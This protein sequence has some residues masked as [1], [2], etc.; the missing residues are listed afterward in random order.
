M[1]Y[2]SLQ[3]LG[4]ALLLLITMVVQSQ[5][6]ASEKDL[7]KHALHELLQTM[8]GEALEYIITPEAMLKKQLANDFSRD[9]ITFYLLDTA[10]VYAVSEN[11]KRYTYTYDEEGKQVIEMLKRFVNEQW[12]NV[13][14]EN[15]NYNDFDL[16][17]EVTSKQWVEN[18]W[19]NDTR[20]NL[21]YDSDE[22]LE[23]ETFEQWDNESWQYTT[24]NH[25]T[26]DNSGKIA[27]VFSE[28]FIGG[29]WV[30]SSNE[31]YIRDEFGNLLELVYQEWDGD[32][33]INQAR[34]L[35]SYT[36]AA[37]NDSSF[38]MTWVDNNWENIYLEA[39]SYNDFQQLIENEGL[40]SIDDEW[41][42][43][44]LFTYEY[45]ESGL[46]ETSIEEVY[47]EGWLPFEKMT[48]IYNEW[49][50]VQSILSELWNEGAWM[51]NLLKNSSFDG[52]G[53]AGTV[54][55]YSWANDSWQ[56]LVDEP[57]TLAYNYGIDQRLFSGYRVVAA[58]QSILVD[59][60]EIYDQVS[61][62]IFP[63]PASNNLTIEHKI[64]NDG[65]ES[66]LVQI[67][68]AQGKLVASEILEN[69]GQQIKLDVSSLSSGQYF[70]T[71]GS[72]DSVESQKIV[73]I[74]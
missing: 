10:V 68:D 43:D 13:S 1:L 66:L 35:N 26:W 3:I 49:G 9:E 32:N 41:V 31:L 42:S 60:A 46:L 47:D 48:M 58:Y 19:V 4:S 6:T 56:Q 73:I 65:L 20:V 67:F 5:P 24:R 7:L 28:Q 50:S 11:P 44:Q 54:Q 34:L 45:N 38:F 17:E 25:F 74:K 53:N 8:P 61:F 71:I 62:S 18:T 51:N 37:L 22:L 40:F 59:V 52:A 72:K 70:V 29:D 57:I 12:V 27:A 39:K 30:N 15:V 21:L 64:Y 14:F 2:K 23:T 16:P 33:W 69:S 63:N 55:V 36:N